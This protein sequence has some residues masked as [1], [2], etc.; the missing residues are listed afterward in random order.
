MSVNEVEVSARNTDHV[1]N[2][3]ELTETQR[4]EIRNQLCS[5]VEAFLLRGGHVQV[6]DDNVRADPPRKPTINYGSSPI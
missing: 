4:R 2:G 6:I 3:S 1:S 5:D